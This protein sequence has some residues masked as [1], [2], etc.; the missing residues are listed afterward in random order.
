MKRASLELFSWSMEAVQRR[1]GWRFALTTSG[2]LSAMTLGTI[3]VQQ[4]YAS[5]LDLKV[6]HGN[7][8]VCI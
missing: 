1:E 6:Q 7:I 3:T 5:N 2:V 4:L 8:E